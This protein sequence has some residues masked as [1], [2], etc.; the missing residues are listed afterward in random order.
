MR[1]RMLVVGGATLVATA[2]SVACVDLFHGTDFVTLCER[3]PSSPSCGGE[4]GV[5]AEAPD[6]A[7]DASKPPIDFCDW[8]PSAARARAEHACAWLGA[9]EGPLGENVFGPCMLH[10]LWA[11]D[12]DLNPTMRPNGETRALW[13]CL[14]EAKSC[15]DVD[16]CV[17]ADGVTQCNAVP[18]G[19]FTACGT[20]GA[21]AVRVECG[22]PEQGRPIGIDPCAL[23]GRSCERLDD[24]TGVCT[25]AKK[26]TCSLGKSCAGTA[27]VDCQSLGGGLVDRGVDCAAFGAGTC[28]EKDGSVACAPQTDAG[29]C[30]R[31]SVDV[32]CAN[33]GGAASSCVGGKEIFVDCTKLSTN[34]T[35]DVDTKPVPA[36]DPIQACANRDPAGSCA[37]SAA[38]SCAGKILRSCAQGIP[39]ALDC[40]SVGLG[41]CEKIAGGVLARCTPP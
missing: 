23:T 14:A 11:Y 9:C 13:A 8:T 18:S 35:C 21:S 2:A 4:G 6:V 40:T 41:A 3:D 27:A 25:G 15:G 33:D 12:C 22:S 32:T 5:D 26:K 37:V 39:F 24:S 38:D 29:A 16:A 7:T 28:V 1:A 36:Y 34:V 17:F 19:S 31:P 20:A 10:A 30:A